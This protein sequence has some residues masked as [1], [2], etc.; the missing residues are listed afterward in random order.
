VRVQS[1]FALAA[2]VVIAVASIVLLASYYTGDTGRYDAALAVG[3]SESAF[4]K[5]TGSS[6]WRELI[7]GD[8]LYGGDVVKNSSEGLVTLRT[9]NGSSLVLKKNTSVQMSADS[10]TASFVLIEGEVYAEVNREPFRILCDGTTVSVKG[11]RFSVKKELGAATVTVLEGLVA[12]SSAET[13]VLVG[14]GQRSVVPAGSRP[15]E[16]VGIDS[17]RELQWALEAPIPAA[18]AAVAPRPGVRPGPV[19]A[20][21]PPPGLHPDQP[22]VPPGEEEVEDADE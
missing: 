8:R 11:T 9:P 21:E 6:A 3:T 4:V 19:G 17:V 7:L 20:L 5:H 1:R 15:S 10:P 18:P 13:E 12:C 22:L 16:P 14:P 2:A